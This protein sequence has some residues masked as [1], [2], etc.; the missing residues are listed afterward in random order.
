MNLSTE[1]ILL[2]RDLLPR[3]RTMMAERVEDSRNAI[4]QGIMAN[5]QEVGVFLVWPNYADRLEGDLFLLD[6]IILEA[7]KKV[8]EET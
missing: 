1:A 3:F 4:A 8:P 6:E 5:D 7:H 2:L